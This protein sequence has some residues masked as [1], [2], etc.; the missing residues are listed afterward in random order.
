MKARKVVW[1]GFGDVDVAFG[2]LL[3]KLH[4]WRK[5]R[6]KSVYTRSGYTKEFLFV[7]T[8]FIKK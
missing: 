7:P 6:P 8:N 3:L 4:V 2:Y 1:L 5:E